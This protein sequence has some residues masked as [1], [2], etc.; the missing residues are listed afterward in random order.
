MKRSTTIGIYLLGTL[1]CVGSTCLGLA[2]N[3]AFTTVAGAVGIVA[4]LA[5]VVLHL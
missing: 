2:T 1:G 4:G 5:G 3:D